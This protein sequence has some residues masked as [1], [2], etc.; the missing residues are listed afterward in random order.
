MP[1]GCRGRRGERERRKNKTGKEKQRANGLFTK[2]AFEDERERERRKS[3]TGKE[4]ERVNG[5]FVN[6]PT[7]S[8]AKGIGGF[9][10]VPSVVFPL[11]LSMFL[12]T[13]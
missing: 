10:C 7:R 1:S 6:N 11:F 5:L 12:L 13:S 3:K 2:A 8:I 4:K 9:L